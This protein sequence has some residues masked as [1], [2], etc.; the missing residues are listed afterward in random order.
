MGECLGTLKSYNLKIYGNK[1]KIQKLNDLI[2]YWNQEVNE[3]IKLFWDFESVKGSYPP[4][5]YTK[6]GRLISD[7]SKKAWQIVKGAKSAEQEEIPVFRGNEIDLNVFSG[8]VIP[9]FGTKEFDLWFNVISLEPHNRLKLPTKKYK[10]LNKALEEGTLRKSFKIFKKKGVFYIKVFVD[11]PGVES[12]NDEIVGI[13]VGLNNTVATSDGKF[14]GNDLK[15]LRIKTKWRKYNGLSAFKQGL[16]RVAKELVVNYPDTDFAV[17]K[18]SFK[19]KGNRSRKFRRRNNNWSY[20]HISHKLSEIG[21][22]K[23]FQVYEVNPK[24]TSRE[25][26]MCGFTDKRNRQG[27]T[28]QCRQC[29]FVGHSDIVGACNIVERVLRDDARPE[30]KYSPIKFYKTGGV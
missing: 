28:F 7:S 9:D 11:I 23:G 12:D 22:L 4:K 20:S 30:T 8:K 6:G 5:E 26:P 17:E 13:D 16:N 10:E 25:C 1:Q 14:F 21:R 19:G 29:G 3:K 2:K 18:L 27:E 15:D 24:D